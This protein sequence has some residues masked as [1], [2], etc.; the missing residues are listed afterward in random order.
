MST[1]LAL[2]YGNISP[3]ENPVK[4]RDE[5]KELSVSLLKDEENLF[6]TISAEEK[7]LYE[8]IIEKML[9][10]G[11]IREEEMFVEGFRLGTKLLLDVLCAN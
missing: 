5:Y 11:C 7:E 8:S 4:R 10:Q 6:K 3:T 1:I 2:Y 9:N